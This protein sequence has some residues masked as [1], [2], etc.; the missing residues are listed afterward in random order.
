MH[1]AANV[2]EIYS[3]PS[4]TNIAF[5][6]E[7][8]R[9]NGNR[10]VTLHIGSSL[11]SCFVQVGVAHVSS[12]SGHT[13]KRRSMRH[14]SFSTENLA[15]KGQ[16]LS[17]ATGIDLIRRT[18]SFSLSSSWLVG[19]AAAPTKAAVRSQP[20]STAA[21]RCATSC[22]ILIRRERLLCQSFGSC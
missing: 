22:R 16:R 13:Y 2:A 15:A 1:C 8:P 19:L 12:F 3:A 18:P 14:P 11:L 17:E 6:R 10:D 7:G 21:C 4:L 20:A 9:W 5:A